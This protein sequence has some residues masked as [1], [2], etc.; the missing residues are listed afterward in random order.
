MGG[1]G[2]SG[3]IVVEAEE[4]VDELEDELEREVS[5]ARPAD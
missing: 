5:E 3:A 1:C 2:W 4:A